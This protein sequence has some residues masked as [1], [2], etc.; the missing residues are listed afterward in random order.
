[1][2]SQQPPNPRPRRKIGGQ[3]G[4]RNALKHALYAQYFPAAMKKTFVKWETT[5]YIGEIQLLRASMDRMAAVLLVQNDI[6]VAEKVAM[7]NGICRA[8]NTLSLLVQR[9][10]A[11]NLHDDPVYTAWD[12]TTSELSFFTDGKPPE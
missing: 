7:L 2:T 6:P 1:M 8:S 12:D 10:R 4:N 5:D 3:P 9:N 11:L